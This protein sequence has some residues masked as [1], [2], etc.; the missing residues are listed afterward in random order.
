MCAYSYLPSLPEITSIPVTTATVEQ[1][2][3][4]DVNATGIPEPNYSL[5]EPDKPE[6]MDI[7]SVSGLIQWTPDASQIGSNP[8]TVKATNLAGS[9]F[10]N[11]SI[12]VD[13]GYVLAGDL[14]NDCRVDFFDFADLARSWLINCGLTP[15]DPACV[16]K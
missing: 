12:E 8:V 13:C 16:P 3:I 9:D 2:Y 11:F 15:E 5:V 6:G 4:Y 7:N 10:Q 1:L 14:N